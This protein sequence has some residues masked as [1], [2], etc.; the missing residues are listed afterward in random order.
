MAVIWGWILAATFV[1][2][3]FA[4][5]WTFLINQGANILL[6]ADIQLVQGSCKTQP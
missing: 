2:H 1:G 4:D 5:Q 6:M 3:T